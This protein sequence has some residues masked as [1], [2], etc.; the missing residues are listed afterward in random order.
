[1]PEQEELDKFLDKNLAKGYIQPSKSSMASPFFFISKKDGK[2]CPCQDYRKLNLGTVK[3]TYPLPL[4]SELIDQLKGAKYFTKLDILWGYNNIQIKD[5]NQWKAAF[6]TNQGLFEPTVMFFGLCNSL[7][8][9]Q[10]MMDDI[11]KDMKHKAW[12]IIYMDNIFIFIKDIA[13]NIENT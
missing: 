8:T 9:F 5:V 11:F 2:L 6:K 7:A 12:I 1:M 13:S 3:N 10:N 4:I